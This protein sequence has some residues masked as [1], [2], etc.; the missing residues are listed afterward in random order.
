MFPKFVCITDEVILG[1]VLGCK[2]LSVGE[3]MRVLTIAYRSRSLW[4]SSSVS[5]IVECRW[6]L[7]V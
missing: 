2:A 1:P 7:K 3:L 6:L 4:P 5:G